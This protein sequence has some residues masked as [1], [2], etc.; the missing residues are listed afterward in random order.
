MT[1]GQEETLKIYGDDI[2]PEFAALRGGPGRTRV[3]PMVGR[4]RAS[5]ASL[6]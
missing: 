4:A 1:H 3:F 5:V 6:P 2:I